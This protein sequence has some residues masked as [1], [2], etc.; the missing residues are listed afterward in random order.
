MLVK[1]QNLSDSFRRQCEIQVHQ[2]CVELCQ[3]HINEQDFVAAYR[4]MP[5]ELNLDAFVFSSPYKCLFP[6]VSQHEM[7]FYHCEDKSQFTPGA[8][9]IQEPCAEASRV[10]IEQCP[11]IFIPGVAFDRRGRRLGMGKGYYDKTLESYEGLKVGV[12]YECQIV[13]EEL[14]HE[15]H[16]LYMDFVITENFTFSPI[17]QKRS[18]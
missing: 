14:P 18:S 8:F 16:D 11:I 3:K 4:S 2:N 12:A 7:S 1:R 17:H 5:G 13:E 9:D 10:D 15:A 6:K